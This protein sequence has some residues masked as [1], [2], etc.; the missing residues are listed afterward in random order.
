MKNLRPSMNKLFTK[1][2]NFNNTM[3]TSHNKP[4]KFLNRFTKFLDCL[5]NLHST[6]KKYLNKMM[7]WPN[8]MNNFLKKMKHWKR[9]MTHCLNNLHVSLNKMKSFLKKMINL[10][11]SLKSYLKKLQHSQIIL[12][13]SNPGDLNMK[14]I[15]KSLMV[16][17]NALNNFLNVN[18]KFPTNCA[19]HYMMQKNN[20]SK[21]SFKVQQELRNSKNLLKNKQCIL[22]RPMANSKR[23][24]K[25]TMHCEKKFT[26]WSSALLKK[27]ENLSKAETYSKSKCKRWICTL[28]RD[29]RI[30]SVI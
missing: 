23:V 7:N 3:T 20:S 18:V 28:N 8:K 6:Q 13:K 26:S 19:I 17:L 16:S 4:M 29:K 1:M 24:R 5:N 21:I 10:L 25:V 15:Y 12:K 11:N 27:K 2:N 9:Q 30:F 22:P 14:M